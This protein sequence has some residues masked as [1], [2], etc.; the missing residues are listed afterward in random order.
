MIDK[1]LDKY[2]AG[3]TSRKEET[4]LAELLSQNTDPR[5]DADRRLICT[6]HSPLPDF[7]KMARRASRRRMFTPMKWVS[8]AASV[9]IVLIAA[10]SLFRQPAPTMETE[11]TVAEATEQTRLALMMFSDAFDRGFE[12][13]DK[14]NDL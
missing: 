2:Y 8:V 6:L 10:S 11:M 3:E 5:Y 13:L 7:G 14:L 12:E 9:A 1:L 4:R